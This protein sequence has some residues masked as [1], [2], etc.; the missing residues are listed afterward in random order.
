MIRHALRLALAAAP[1][2]FELTVTLL[3]QA[4]MRCYADDSGEWHTVGAALSGNEEMDAVHK[5]LVDS[6]IEL[7]VD[8]LTSYTDMDSDRLRLRCVGL[9]GAGEALSGSMVR[10]EA[11]EAQ[12]ADAFAALMRGSLSNEG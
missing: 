4:Y 3:A 10:G 9:V 11:S 2:D 12:A 7:F 1:R 6:Y 5:E 8:A